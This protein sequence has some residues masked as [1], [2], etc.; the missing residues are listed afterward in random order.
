MSTEG[1]TFQ[2]LMTGT[3]RES[4]WQSPSHGDHFCTPKQ[5]PF[6]SCELRLRFSSKI[7]ASATISNAKYDLY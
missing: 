7:V 1:S 6:D 3:H 5:P 2:S 4:N